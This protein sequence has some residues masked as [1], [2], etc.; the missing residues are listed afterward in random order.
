MPCIQDSSILVPWPKS[1]QTLSLSKFVYHTRQS[2]IP[3]IFLSTHS[4]ASMTPLSVLTAIISPICVM[5]L[6]SPARPPR[7]TIP[8]SFEF[9]HMR[10]VGFEIICALCSTGKPSQYFKPSHSRLEAR[11]ACVTTPS[12]SRSSGSAYSSG[13][14][15][16]GW[17]SIVSFQPV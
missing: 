14:S 6:T 7:T 11:F 9:S 1:V 3:P 17:F 16:R 4:L 2:G 13:V 15:V 5:P 10:F 12:V 8:N